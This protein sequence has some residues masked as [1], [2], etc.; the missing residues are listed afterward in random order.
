MP[1]DGVAV[2]GG[3]LVVEV[4]VSFSEGDESGDNVITGGV[5]VVEW[6][7]AEPVGKGVNAEGSLL[8]EEDTQ[9]AS[10]DESSPPVSPAETCDEAGED[11]AHEDDGL[12]VVAVL[13]DDN[14]VVVQVGDVSAAN[15]LGVLLHQHPADMRVHEALSD[16]VGVL[17]S[18]GVTVVSAMVSGPP[19]DRALDGPAAHGCEEHLEGEGC[20]VGAMGPEAVI[21]WGCVSKRISRQSQYNS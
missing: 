3:E 21:T 10:V 13:P 15:S 20:G 1:L 5:A 11:H 9:D 4:V 7:V 16:G 19:A 14:S 18:V 6:L 8:D 12:D 2:V 17:V